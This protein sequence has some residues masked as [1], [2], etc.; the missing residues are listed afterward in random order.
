MARRE[1]GHASQFGAMSPNADTERVVLGVLSLLWYLAF[2][3]AVILLIVE[4]HR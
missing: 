1:S 3:A 4:W 2:L